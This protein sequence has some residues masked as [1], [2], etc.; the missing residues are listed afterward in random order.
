MTLFTYVIDHRSKRL[1][2]AA[3]DSVLLF[4]LAYVGNMERL[5]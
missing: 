2:C 5:V 3:Q 1:I 4:S